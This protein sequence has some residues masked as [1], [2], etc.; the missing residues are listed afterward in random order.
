MLAEN[1]RVEEAVTALAGGDLPAVGRLLSA[2]HRSLRDL[3]SSSTPAVES[4]VER[5]MRAGAAG[6][7]MVGGGFGGNVLA[8]SPLA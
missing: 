1:Q 6:A 3:Y 2:S 5:V 7:R 4:T 8:C